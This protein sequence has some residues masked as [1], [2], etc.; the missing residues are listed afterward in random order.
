MENPVLVLCIM[1]IVPLSFAIAGEVKRLRATA[2]PRRPIVR[3]RRHA[4]AGA[5]PI[6]FPNP[7]HIPVTVLAE[8]RPDEPVETAVRGR[9]VYGFGRIP[10][11]RTRTQ[12]AHH[13]HLL[14]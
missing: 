7:A 3:R 6:A 2:K 1:I 12:P 11:R 4:D 9:A 10:P 5:A 8:S 13:L 14:R